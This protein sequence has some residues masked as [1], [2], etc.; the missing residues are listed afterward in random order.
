MNPALVSPTREHRRFR[1]KSGHGV[2]RTIHRLAVTALIL[3]T[4]YFT[5]IVDDLQFAG[6]TFENYSGLGLDV[7]DTL[8]SP[9]LGVRTDILIGMPTFRQTRSV[10]IDF[11]ACR[12]W[13]D[14]LDE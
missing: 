7:L 9:I 1:S 3:T 13:V 8:L 6:R 12:M 10:T 4:D 11:P 14:W 5:P 2:I